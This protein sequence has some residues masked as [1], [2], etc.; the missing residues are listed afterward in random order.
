MFYTPYLNEALQQEKISMNTI[1]KSAMRVLPFWFKLGLLDPPNLVPFTNYTLNYFYNKHT[2][3][4]YQSAL[5]SIVLLKNNNHTLPLIAYFPLQN[6]GT[7]V[8]VFFILFFCWLFFI[9]VA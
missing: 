1:K 5:K 9:C 4:A 6:Q 3:I 8:W 2:S 7:N